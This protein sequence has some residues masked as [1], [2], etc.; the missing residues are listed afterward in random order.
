MSAQIAEV[1]SLG[2]SPCDPFPAEWV[3]GQFRCKLPMEG[4]R[5]ARPWG[6]YV[7][8]AV[9]AGGLAYVAYRVTRRRPPRLQGLGR[10]RRR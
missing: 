5:P 9:L 7:G 8:G 4:E 1:A 6:L 3:N 2:R 10:R